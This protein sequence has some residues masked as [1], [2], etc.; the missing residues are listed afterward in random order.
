MQVLIEDSDNHTSNYEGMQ[1]INQT[2]M[3][4]TSIGGVTT[5]MK[6]SPNGV[7]DNMSY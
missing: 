7:H 4:D 5:T 1:G 3:N 2:I 6:S